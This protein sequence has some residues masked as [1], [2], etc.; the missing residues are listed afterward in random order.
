[1]DGRLKQAASR[2]ESL[3]V[4][5]ERK[6]GV[7]INAET[8]KFDSVYANDGM[9]IPLNDKKT[10]V[11]PA[12]HIGADSRIGVSGAN[13]SGKSTLI[14]HIVANCRI[15]REKLIYIPQEISGEE[16]EELV[17]RLRSLKKDELGEALST[18]SRLGSD[19]VA[20][21][22]GESPS[23]GETRKIMLALGISSSP[24]CIVMDEPTNH[25]DIPSI[26]SVET[27]LAE[28]NCALLLVSHDE[29][30]LESLTSEHWAI[31][32]GSSNEEYRLRILLQYPDG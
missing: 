7:S 21:L 9:R 5:G 23:P 4:N 3:K 27:A 17:E 25:M 11:V 18:V 24:Y 29:R 10:L 13:G 15:D 28:S 32:K 14:N 8:G 20:L 16:T 1:M 30:F 6:L 2:L 31:E 19:P 26:E 22:K 12:I